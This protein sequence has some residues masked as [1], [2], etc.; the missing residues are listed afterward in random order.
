[1]AIGKVGMTVGWFVQLDRDKKSIALFTFSVLCKFPAT[2]ARR[3][4]FMP[5]YLYSKLS[6]LFYV[7]PFPVLPVWL[8]QVHGGLLKSE[9]SKPCRTTCERFRDVLYEGQLFQHKHFSMEFMYIRADLIM[10]FNIL[11]DE[12]DHHSPS[13]FFFRPPRPL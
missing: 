4:L 12:I 10:A 11:K 13:D 9:C 6:N 8:H 7:A 5:L 1:M 3:W 2:K